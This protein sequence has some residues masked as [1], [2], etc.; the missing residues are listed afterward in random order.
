MEKTTSVPN[1]RRAAGKFKGA[2]IRSVCANDLPLIR[3][4][5]F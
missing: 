3:A 2:S 5:G 1:N 4:R